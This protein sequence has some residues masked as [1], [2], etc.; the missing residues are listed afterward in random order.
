MEEIGGAGMVKAAAKS[1]QHKEHLGSRSIGV[2]LSE[3]VGAGL[4][5]EAS[6]YALEARRAVAELHACPHQMKPLLGSLGFCQRAHNGTRFPRIYVGEAKGVPFL[7]SSDIIGLRPE[8]GNFISRKHTPKLELL[9]IE[10]WMVLVSRS[11]TI[12]NV[13]LAGPRMAGWALSEDAIRIIAPDAE[14]AGYITAFLR[15]HWG[16]DQLR[17]LTY[18]S[19]I[20]HI[21]AHHL[22]SVE[23]PDL[24]AL[25]RTEIGRAFVGAVLKRDEA[26]DKLDEAGVRFCQALGLPPL[27]V[28][29]G[30]PIVSAVRASEWSGRLEASYHNPNA[31]WLERHL[32][33]IGLPVLPLHSERLTTA[34]RAVTKFRKRVYVPHGGI[35]LLSSKQLFQIDPIEQKGLARGA[36]ESDMEEIALATNM[37]AITCSGTVGRVQIIPEYMNGWAANQHALRITAVDSET[38]GYLYAWLS[39]PYGQALLSR[40]SYGSVIVEIDRFMAGEIP[41]P[42]LPADERKHIGRL[43]L[44]ANRLRDEAWRMEQTALA[45]LRKEISGDAASVRPKVAG[46]T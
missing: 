39:T 1:A 31:R 11:G 20:Q 18:G 37:V 27:P 13:A 23:V 26:N 28:Q 40:Y 42:V 41:V 36:H 38:A 3:V 45:A 4:R 19:V 10:P 44:A 12:G 16:R 24:P 17:G 14:T 8:R 43:V 2:R 33:A 29:Q 32:R 46:R 35:P 34:V 25:R 5:L 7:S 6:A 15:S 22:T 30:G 9:V 21:E